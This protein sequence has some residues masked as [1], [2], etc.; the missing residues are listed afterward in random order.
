M[1]KNFFGESILQPGDDI[2][3]AF[4]EQFDTSLDDTLTASSIEHEEELGWTCLIADGGLNEMQAHDFESEQ[5][6]CEWLTRQGVQIDA[7]R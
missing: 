7:G 4:A 5:A 1:K 3:A 6:L 2:Y